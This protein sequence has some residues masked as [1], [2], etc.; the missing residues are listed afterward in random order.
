MV[1]RLQAAARRSFAIREAHTRLVALVLYDLVDAAA[2]SSEE[3]RAALEDRAALA[4]QT[5]VRK[6]Q[7]HKVVHEQLQ[8]REQEELAALEETHGQA[9][10]EETESPSAK[11][12]TPREAGVPVL[13]PDFF[14]LMHRSA[15]RVQVRW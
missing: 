14:Q 10:D 3:S 2:D 11:E 1:L 15:V 4:I 13:E 6:H 12:T 5:R 7:A 9:V 8:I